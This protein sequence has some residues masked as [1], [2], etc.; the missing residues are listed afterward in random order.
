[1][2][3]N[4]INIVDEVYNYVGNFKSLAGYDKFNPHITL[5]SGIKNQIDM[6]LPPVTF[7]IDKINL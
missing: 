3:E 5:G 4:D 7:T 6:K 2:T 1:M